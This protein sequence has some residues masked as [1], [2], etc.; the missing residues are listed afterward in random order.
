[1][2][3]MLWGG[4]G[5]PPGLRGTR[6]ATQGHPG[7]PT[8]SGDQGSP[9]SAHGVLSFE[10]KF[11]AEKEGGR[12]EAGSKERDFLCYHDSARDSELKNFERLKFSVGPGRTAEKKIF[13]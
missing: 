2:A 5:D 10:F 3:N 13:L 12:K 6:R 8:R 9:G 4:S 11:L 1:M 7:P